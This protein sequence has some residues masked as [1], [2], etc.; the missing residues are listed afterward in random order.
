[1]LPEPFLTTRGFS[2]IE[3]LV[4]TA[5]LTVSLLSLVPL[6]TMATASITDAA[7]GT[8]AA[9]L[10]QQKLEQ[11]RIVPATDPAAFSA[12]PAAALQQ[13]TVGYVDYVDADGSVLDSS[14]TKA[15]RGASFTRRWSI[16]PIAADP[17]ATV[18]IQVL[19]APQRDSAAHRPGPGRSPGAVRL[20]TLRTQRVR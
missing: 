6:F 2:L 4:A 12:S 19:V 1:M 3:V 16:E 5:M 20:V 17:A 8:E 9:V 15:P 10:A 7:Y 18:V 14:S 13:N 11:L